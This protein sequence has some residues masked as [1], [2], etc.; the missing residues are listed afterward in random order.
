MDKFIQITK[1]VDGFR[2][3]TAISV[4]KNVNIFEL[5]NKKY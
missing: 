4:P 1:V 5:I 3:V 2:S